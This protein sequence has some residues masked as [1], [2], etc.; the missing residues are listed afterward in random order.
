M[1]THNKGCVPPF[2]YAVSQPCEGRALENLPCRGRGTASPNRAACHAAGLWQTGCRRAVSPAGAADAV[3]T[4]RWTHAGACPG[5]F[6]SATNRLDP[7]GRQSSGASY[8]EA[9]LPWRGEHGS[10]V[11]VC[12]SR[13][14]RCAPG[15]SASQAAKAYGGSGAPTLCPLLPGLPGLALPQQSHGLAA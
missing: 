9:G 13:V 5:P 15:P 7:S 14:L 12:A 1:A 8:R 4:P 10:A 3:L 11:C 6:S 2:T